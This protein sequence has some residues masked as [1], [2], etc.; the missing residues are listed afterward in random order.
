M[1][2]Q[3]IIHLADPVEDHE[4][5]NKQ[6][7]NYQLQEVKALVQHILE[8]VEALELKTQGVTGTINTLTQNPT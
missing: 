3:P 8:R 2:F 4:G 7:L 1:Q 6:F 5:V